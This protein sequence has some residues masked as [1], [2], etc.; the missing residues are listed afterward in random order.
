LQAFGALAASVLFAIT[1]A[2]A[3]EASLQRREQA[4]VRAIFAMLLD[5]MT[6]GDGWHF[7]RPCVFSEDW[8]DLELDRGRSGK[9]IHPHALLSLREALDH[10]GQHPERFCD[11]RVRNDEA[12]AAAR[13]LPGDDNERITTADMDF[14]YPVFARGRTRAILQHSGGNDSWFKNGKSDFISSWRYVY[15]RKRRGAWTARFETLGIAN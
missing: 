7:D 3:G 8:I 6:P 13:A 4:D 15:L 2:N 12:K 5:R 1:S 9:S 14:S 11:R 10:K